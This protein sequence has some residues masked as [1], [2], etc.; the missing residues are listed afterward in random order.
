MELPWEGD[1]EQNAEAERTEMLGW[2]TNARLRIPTALYSTKELKGT[3]SQGHQGCEGHT[4]PASLGGSLVGFLH[5]PG[6]MR[7]GAVR[8]CSHETT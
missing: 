2:I 3:H 1:R 7:G 8:Q 5:Q 4:A 6:L